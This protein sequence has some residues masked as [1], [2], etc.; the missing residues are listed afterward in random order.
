MRPIAVGDTVVDKELDTENGEVLTRVAE[1]A[2]LEV[3]DRFVVVTSTSSGTR[4]F[5]LVGLVPT[6]QPGHWLVA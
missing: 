3:H 6:A 4:Q 5:E 2:V 1:Y